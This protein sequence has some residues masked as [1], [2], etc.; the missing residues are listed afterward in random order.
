MKPENMKDWERRLSNEIRELRAI[1]DDI[2]ALQQHLWEKP[3]EITMPSFM[4]GS[5]ME[6]EAIK[7]LSYAEKYL[8]IDMRETKL[9]PTPIHRGPDFDERLREA[10][11]VDALMEKSS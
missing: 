6:D 4:I 2:K 5:E 11:D 1:N 7:L 10:M 9:L 8:T 3:D